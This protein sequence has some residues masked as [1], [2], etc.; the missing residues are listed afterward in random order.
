MSLELLSSHI[1]TWISS[2]YTRTLSIA[3]D[4]KHARNINPPQDV[5]YNQIST[6]TV[7]NS[8]HESAANLNSW[9]V[10]ALLFSNPV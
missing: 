4:Y 8:H 2:V 7:F 5:E 9:L 3:Q 10:S 1:Q 6:H